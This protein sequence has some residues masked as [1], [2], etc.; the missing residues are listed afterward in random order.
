M[1]L[2]LSE[3]GHERKALNVGAVLAEGDIPLLPK[4]SLSHC[5]LACLLSHL[6]KQISSLG[7]G[8]ADALIDFPA[9]VL[10]GYHTI[11]EILHPS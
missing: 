9:H 7:G 3:R 11:Q 8:V 1:H 6:G 10:T 4:V 5:L 2:P